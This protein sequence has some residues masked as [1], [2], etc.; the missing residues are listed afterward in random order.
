MN[1][2]DEIFKKMVRFKQKFEQKETVKLE[3]SILNLMAKAGKLAVLWIGIALVA[4]LGIAFAVSAYTIFGN[5]F[6]VVAG[7]LFWIAHPALTKKWELIGTFGITLLVGN[8][9]GLMGSVMGSSATGWHLIFS[10]IF[11]VF[12]GCLVYVSD[13]LDNLERKNKNRNK[14]Y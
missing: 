4:V 8:I 14:G 5:I 11:M 3:D 9:I 7:G 6:M 10:I 2:L 1:K 12:G 13:K